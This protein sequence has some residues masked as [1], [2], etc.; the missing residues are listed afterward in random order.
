VTTLAEQ[1]PKSPA[2]V[3]KIVTL[4]AM[5]TLLR[6]AR[7]QERTIQLLTRCPAAGTSRVRVGDTLLVVVR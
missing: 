7:W 2:K 1:S 4:K 6:Q 5:E 3:T